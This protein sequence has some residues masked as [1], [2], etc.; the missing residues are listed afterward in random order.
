MKHHLARETRSLERIHKELVF[1]AESSKQHWEADKNFLA[2]L[3]AE[4][5]KVAKPCYSLP[6]AFVRKIERAVAQMENAER[7]Y[8]KACEARNA[9]RSLI[10]AGRI[11]L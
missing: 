7:C 1:H 2:D 4:R 5:N 10:E 6:I 9:V 11:D 3:Q 8:A